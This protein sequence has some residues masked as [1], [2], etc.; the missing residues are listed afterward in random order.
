[1]GRE[2][3]VTVILGAPGMGK[4]ALVKRVV[5]AY[6]R[7]HGAK[8]VRALDPSGALPG[9]GE[10]PGRRNTTAWIEEL[11]AEGEGPGAGGWGPGLLVLDD[12]DRYLLPM[13]LDAWRDVWLAN[14]HLG[15]DV[16]V[17]GHRAPAL[18]KD[19]LG[20][21]SEFWLFAQEEVR[22]LDYLAS[23]P[24]LRGAFKGIAS[25]LPAVKGLAL[26]V[27]PATR[28]VQLMRIWPGAGVDAPPAAV[29]AVAD[30]EA[31]ERGEVALEEDEDEDE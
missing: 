2:R 29:E 18:P 27:V 30:D 10:W 19:L 22:A 14:R 26:R 25:P 15:L 24:T 6:Q 12:A 23:I 20:A 16:I 13:S 4:T 8:S 31:E 3:K 17:T 1:M 9:L 21:A 5:A 11:T 28:S 7:Q